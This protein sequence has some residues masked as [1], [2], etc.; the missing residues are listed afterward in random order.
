MKN[1]SAPNKSG[2]GARGRGQKDPGAKK[3]GR[4]K[5]I[6]VHMC[7]GPCSIYPLKV[8]MKEEA[9]ITGFFH[10]PNIHPLSEFRSRLGA[11]KKLSRLMG[12]DVIYDEEY[13]PTS[14]IRNVKILTGKDAG[15]AKRPPFAERCAYCY[16]SRLE[17]TAR[18]GF[19]LGFDAFTTSLLYSKYQNHADIVSRGF[20]L[21][22]K[23]GVEFFYRDFRG[24][25]YEGINE[26][27]ALGL[28]RQKYCG[29]IYSKIERDEEKRLRKRL[30]E[31][32]KKLGKACG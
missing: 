26:S 15:E 19:E 3:K 8:I 9:E 29:C 24:G 5:K 21:E 11:V 4:V 27:R 28:Y 7:C 17:E 16:S 20:E 25:W 13:R 6:L 1:F 10:N 12:L 22:K 23:Y 32:R 30:K 2:M 14:F 18:A 31:E